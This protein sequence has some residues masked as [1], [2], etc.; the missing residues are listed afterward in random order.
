MSTKFWVGQRVGQKIAVRDGH[1]FKTSERRGSVVDAGPNPVLVV[2]DGE[3]ASTA[4][5]EDQIYSVKELGTISGLLS[6]FTL[7]PAND[8]EVLEFFWGTPSNDLVYVNPFPFQ[9]DEPEW[10]QVLRRCPRGAKVFVGIFGEDFIYFTPGEKRT[11]MVPMDV[12]Q[13]TLWKGIVCLYR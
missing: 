6:E 1:S 12:D 13:L 9:P 11:F 8:D 3:W 5:H 10:S 4:V 2:F 7:R